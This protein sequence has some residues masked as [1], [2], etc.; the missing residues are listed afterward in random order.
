MAQKPF[1][2]Y[3]SVTYMLSKLDWRSLE[4]RRID[5]RLIMFYKIVHGYVA[6]QLQT[7]FD[8][9]LR[10]ARHMHPLPFRQIHTGASYYQYSF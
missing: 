6:I 4:D 5:T 2:P 8:K 3:E 10:Y 9:P 7:Y 1:S